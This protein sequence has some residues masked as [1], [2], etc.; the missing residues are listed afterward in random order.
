M[1]KKKFPW[2]RTFLVGFGFFGISI[3]WPIFNQWVPLILQVGNP[4]F[5]SKVANF[6]GFGLGPAMAM[7]IMTWDN[8]INIFVQPWV[9]ARSDNTW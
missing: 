3:L 4:E 9:G 8:I 6:V 2:G 5:E 7:F 1:E